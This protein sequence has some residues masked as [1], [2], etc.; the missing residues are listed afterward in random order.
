M[1]DLNGDVTAEKTGRPKRGGGR[2]GRHKVRSAPL[3]ADVKPVRPGLSGGQYRPLTG[4]QMAQIEQTIYQILDEIGLSQAPESGIAYMTAFGARAGDD[5]RRARDGG[6]E[7][8]GEGVR[9]VQRGDEEDAGE[10]RVRAVRR[11]QVF[12]F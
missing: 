11:K 7:D 9:A 12:V 3:A 8:G 5:G 2:M 6:E 1:D 4:V 10:D